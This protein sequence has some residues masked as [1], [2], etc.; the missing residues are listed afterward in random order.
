MPGTPGNSPTIPPTAAPAMA[1]FD[2][3]NFFTPS[4]ILGVKPTHFTL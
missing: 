4:K 1:R 2:P 3:P